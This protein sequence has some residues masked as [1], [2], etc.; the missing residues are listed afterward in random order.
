M[1]LK[2]KKILVAFFSHPGQNYS[3]GRIVELKI[4]N[5]AIVADMISELTD[6]HMFEI[7]S[8]KEYPSNYNACTAEAK[9]EL[10]SNLRPELAED[11]DISSYDIIFL[12]YPNW[13]G[14]MPMPVWTFLEKHNFTGKIIFPFCTHEGSGMGNSESDIRNMATGADI[15]NGFAIHGSSASKAEVSVKNWIMKE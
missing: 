8:V 11:I 7:R 1:D 4:G 3:N 10:K 5:T 9:D 6:A 14:T 2:D 13:W 15:K 12:G